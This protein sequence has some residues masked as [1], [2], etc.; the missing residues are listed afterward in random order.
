MEKN[1]K[2][3]SR[4]R[5]LDRQVAV[6]FAR[7]KH[8][9]RTTICYAVE[10]RERYEKFTDP[11][12][13]QRFFYN[14]LAL[15]MREKIAGRKIALW[16]IMT[17]GDGLI[18]EWAFVNRPGRAVASMWMGSLSSGPDCC[19]SMIGIKEPVGEDDPF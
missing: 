10:V 12:M 3:F 1:Y 13:A 14:Q 2:N 5:R 19:A 15:M 18:R 6:T 7:L 9:S 4:T 8:R 11:Y 17:N 16:Q